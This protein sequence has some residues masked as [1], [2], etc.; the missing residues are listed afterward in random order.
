MTEVRVVPPEET[1]ALRHRV[2]RPHQTVEEVR[3]RLGTLPA[4]AV[5]A[6]GVVVAT[7]TVFPEPFPDDPR[8]GDWRLRGMASAPEARGMGYGATALLAALD[9]A[10]AHGARRVWC[11]ARTAALGFYRRYGFT[12]HGDEFDDPGSGPHYRASI[13]L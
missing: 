9:H 4:I 1:L 12:T 5:Y 3:A 2:L 13:E 7:A 10:R 11:N 6:D 8:P